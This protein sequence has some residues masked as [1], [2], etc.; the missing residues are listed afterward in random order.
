VLVLIEYAIFFPP[1]NGHGFNLSM[2]PILSSNLHCASLTG[3]AWSFLVLDEHIGTVPFSAK[4]VPIVK[5][6]FAMLVVI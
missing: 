2:F 1:Q 5:A 3:R 6:T 4:Y